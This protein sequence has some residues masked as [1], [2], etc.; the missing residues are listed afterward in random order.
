MG[1]SCEAAD[2]AAGTNARH[3]LAAYSAS[4]TQVWAIPSALG[5]QGAAVPS[6]VGVS[7]DNLYASL[8]PEVDLGS[9]PVLGEGGIYAF[10][11]WDAVLAAVALIRASAV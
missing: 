4:G 1:P 9:G 6:R 2:D 5:E 10:P 7:D 3:W 11:D 8:R